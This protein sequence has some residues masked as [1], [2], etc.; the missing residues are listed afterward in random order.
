LPSGLE[1]CGNCIDDDGDGLVDFE[2]PECCGE[3]QSFTLKKGRL[4]PADA[5]TKL[6][7]KGSLGSLDLGTFPPATHDVFVQVRAEGGDDMLCAQIPAAS[8]AAKK[9]RLRFK[10]KTGAVASAQGLSQL[11]LRVRKDGSVALATR[12]KQVLFATPSAGRVHV[13]MGFRNPATADVGNQC[14]SGVETF[15]A[16]GKKGALKFP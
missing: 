14:R 2:D 7:L 6:A 9:K 5:G 13:T 10:D 4:R 16:I 15:R 8:L 11:K 12:G 3:T 1:T